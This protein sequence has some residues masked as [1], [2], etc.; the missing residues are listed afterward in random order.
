MRYYV[1]PTKMTLSKKRKKEERGREGRK[2]GKKEKGK[3]RTNV[4][5]DMEKFWR[6]RDPYRLMVGM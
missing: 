5:N 2:R 3:E 6:N 1:I 4:D